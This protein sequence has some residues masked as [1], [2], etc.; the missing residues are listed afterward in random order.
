MIKVTLSKK[1]IKA[2]AKLEQKLILYIVRTAYKF[3][4]NTRWNQEILLL[5]EFSLYNYRCVNYST[6][7]EKRKKL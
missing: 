7:L 3:S 6:I 1:L 2:R 4:L 5:I